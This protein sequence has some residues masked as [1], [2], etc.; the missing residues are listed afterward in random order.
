[1]SLD[2]SEILGDNTSGSFTIT[3]NSLTK[4]IEYLKGETDSKTDLE[5]LFE[6]I[7]NAAKELVKSQPNMALIRRTNYSFVSYFKRFLK[8]EKSRKDVIKMMIAKLQETEKELNENL[9]AI[10]EYGSRLITNFN[11]IL[12]FSSSTMVR[13]IFE[14]ADDFKRKFE[15]YCLKS[16]PP[17]EGV[18]LAEHLSKRD[19]KTTIVADSQAGAVMNDMNMVLVGADRLYENGFVNKAGT[20]AVCLL[21]R[22]YN[23]PV[24]LAVETI[25]ILKES[26]RSIKQVEG[27][28]AEVYTGKK[29]IDVYNG[30]YEKIPLD[31]VNKVIC[32]E[33]VFET[34]DFLSWYL[35]E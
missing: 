5:S 10:S 1:M 3:R 24:Y 33:G 16:D 21:A 25:K 20:L 17:L 23:V 31:L 34:S 18:M 15:V 27:D 13:Q 19:I 9:K 26:E 14:K 22:H 30:Y 32:E 7:Q 12:T 28:K 29:N 35:G 6:E 2:I 8:S 11:K 4:Y